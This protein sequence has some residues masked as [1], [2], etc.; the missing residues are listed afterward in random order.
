MVY[1]VEKTTHIFIFAFISSPINFHKL[2]RLYAPTHSL[3]TEPCLTTQQRS[4]EL[5]KI[6]FSS[7]HHV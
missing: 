4:W 3:T 7:N 5:I 6:S 2:N 1:L